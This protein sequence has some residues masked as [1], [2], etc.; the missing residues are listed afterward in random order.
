VESAATCSVHCGT[1]H[2]APDQLPPSV[3]LH[4][5]NPVLGAAATE[6]AMAAMRSIIQQRARFDSMFVIFGRGGTKRGAPD[7][8]PPSVKPYEVDPVLDAQGST[9]GLFGSTS[10]G[11]FVGITAPAVAMGYGRWSP[12]SCRHGDCRLCRRGYGCPSRLS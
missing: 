10:N 6:E 11:V 3:K 9:R 4:E 5:A 1:K 7:D 12:Y 8:L 2:G